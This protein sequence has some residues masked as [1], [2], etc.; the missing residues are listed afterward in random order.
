LPRRGSA[1]QIR[2]E[3]GNIGGA[4]STLAGEAQAFRR[5]DDEARRMGRCVLSN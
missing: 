4:R 5:G 3:A 2:E 1:Q